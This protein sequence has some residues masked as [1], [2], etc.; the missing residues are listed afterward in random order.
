MDKKVECL[1]NARQNKVPSMIN[2]SCPLY[3]LDGGF[4]VGEKG[5]IGIG[6]VEFDLH[7]INVA[8]QVYYYR[9]WGKFPYNVKPCISTGCIERN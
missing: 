6:L 4:K 8:N 5:V 1:S 9:D 3:I 2:Q 7:K